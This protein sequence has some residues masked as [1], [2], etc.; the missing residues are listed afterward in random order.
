DVQL[1][2][3]GMH[4]V[5]NMVAAICIASHLKISNDKIKLAVEDFKGVKRRFEYILK[6]NHFVFIDDYAH[7]PEELKALIQGAKTLFTQR[8]CTIIF[9][10]HL[11][12]RTRDFADGFA[13]SLD[14]ADNIIL[15][16]IY[17]AR[18]L[19]IEGI[20]SKTILDKMKNENKRVL[21]KEQLMQWIEN[22]YAGNRDPEF[23]EILITAGAGN[24]DAL[25][26]PIKKIVAE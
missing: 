23:G 11:F 21:T 18:E 13:E 17:P 6:N 7:H 25:V 10:P 5:E 14:L 12:T 20:T 3:G 22:D 2:M 16:P 8:R 26:Q 4:N 15:L 1:H 9:Q 24:I 19:P